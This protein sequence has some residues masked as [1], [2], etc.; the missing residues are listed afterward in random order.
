MD[1]QSHGVG[2]DLERSSGTCINFKAPHLNYFWEWQ[3]RKFYNLP[4]EPILVFDSPRLG[5]MPL[6]AEL[7]DCFCW[8]E[9]SAI[10]FT[11]R[12]DNVESLYKRDW[13]TYRVRG[14][15]RYSNFRVQRTGFKSQCWRLLCVWP[16]ANYFTSLSTTFLIC[17]MEPWPQSML[18]TPYREED[19]VVTKLWYY[20]RLC[21]F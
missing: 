14:S 19:V 12:V 1:L 9:I 17:K 2:K 5:K 8:E 21:Y 4:Q 20:S 7:S 6:K 3:K 10:C 18:G 16:Q 11:Q 15:K 13:L